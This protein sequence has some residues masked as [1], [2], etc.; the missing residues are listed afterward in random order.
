MHSLN[1]LVMS[2]NIWEHSKSSNCF[3]TITSCSFWR[4]EMYEGGKCEIQP[5][6]RDPGDTLWWL[7][8]L[9]ANY[10]GPEPELTLN[11]FSCPVQLGEQQPSPGDLCPC[12]QEWRILLSELTAAFCHQT[13]LHAFLIEGLTVKIKISKYYITSSHWQCLKPTGWPPTIIPR[14]PTAMGHVTHVLFSY[15]SLPPQSSLRLVEL[16]TCWAK[17]TLWTRWGAAT[18]DRSFNGYSCSG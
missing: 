8:R 11:C 16:A 9:A 1:N 17:W 2:K 13:M 12:C 10:P 14:V 5:G 7:A 4:K 15:W 6:R 18:H 3:V